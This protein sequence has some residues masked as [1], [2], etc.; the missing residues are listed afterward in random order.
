MNAG[1]ASHDVISSPKLKLGHPLPIAPLFT[2]HSL[3]S[4][5]PL[6]NSNSNSNSKTRFPYPFIEFHLPLCE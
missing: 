6:Y 4:H 2:I 3:G 5:P 1:N